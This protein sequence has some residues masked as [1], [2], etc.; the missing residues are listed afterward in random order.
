MR[1]PSI[2]PSI[3]ANDT[4]HRAGGTSKAGGPTVITPKQYKMRFREAIDGYLLLSPTP[5]LDMAALGTAHGKLP[6]TTTP[7]PPNDDAA[8][9]D[10]ASIILPSSATSTYSAPP[11]SDTSSVIAAASLAAF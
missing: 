5:W 9:A 3:A 4:L 1:W 10:N 11:P 8:A 7:V 6:K 2:S